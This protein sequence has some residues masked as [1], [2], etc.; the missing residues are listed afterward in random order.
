MNLKTPIVARTSICI[1]TRIQRAVH[2]KY[3]TEFRKLTISWNIDRYSKVVRR[4]SSLDKQGYLLLSSTC[5][6]ALLDPTFLLNVLWIFGTTCLLTELILV[7]FLALNVQSNLST[8]VPLYTR[9]AVYFGLFYYDLTCM[10]Y[11][12]FRWCRLLVKATVSAVMS[13]VC[14]ATA[15][16]FAWVLVYLHFWRINDDDD[17]DDKDTQQSGRP[18]Q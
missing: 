14:L 18:L 10:N 16:V 15:A 4:H 2:K 12:Y 6:I 11:C 1:F 5:V 8:F 17:D 7:H 3:A 13:L 9:C